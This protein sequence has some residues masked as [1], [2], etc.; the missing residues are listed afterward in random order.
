MGLKKLDF[1]LYCD[2]ACRGNPGPSS[3]GVIARL[4][5]QTE[6]GRGGMFLGPGTNNSAEW[7]GAVGA[8]KFTEEVMEG[9]APRVGLLTGLAVGRV[10]I[11]MDS[12]LVVNQ[13]T[14]AWKIKEPRLRVFYNQA[15]AIVQ[16]L[17]IPVE[18]EWVPREQNAEADNIANQCLDQR[19]T[20]GVRLS[21]KPGSGHVQVLETP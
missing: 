14:G 1:I 18:F 4:S 19:S 10:I 7:Q 6:V 2:G 12:L 3:Y 20:V 11:R 15:I 17:N 8:L 16:K 13:M 21:G 5:D 9:P